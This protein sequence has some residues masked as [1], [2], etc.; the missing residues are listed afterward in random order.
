MTLADLDGDGQAEIL[1]GTSVYNADGS[2]R[3]DRRTLSP[4]YV[5]GSSAGHAAQ[6]AVDFDLDGTLEIIAGPSAYDRDGNRLWFWQRISGTTLRGTLDGGA[7]V[8][9]VPSNSSL[10]DAYT[11]VAN[12]DDDPFPEIIAVSTHPGAVT[13]FAEHSIQVFEH[14]GRLKVDFPLFQNTGPL[15][16]HLGPPTVADVN[17]DGRPDIAVV[18]VKQPSPAPT[19]DLPRPILQV[20]A[21]QADNTLHLQWQ[22]DL[23][24]T[25]NPYP[26]P[27]SAFDFDGDGAAELVVLDNHRL[28]ILYGRDGTTLFEM[29]VD[30]TAG[31][32]FASRYPTIADVDNDGSADIIVPTSFIG[33]AQAGAPPRQGLL[34]LSD[35]Q[36]HWLN[37]RRVWNQHPYHVTNVNED[38]S[39]PRLPRHNW[40]IYNTHRTQSQ[41]E[42]ETAFAAPDLT[43]S[44]VTVQTEHCPAFLGLTARIGNGGSWHAPAGLP[45]DFYNGHPG[46]GGTLLGSRQTTR[47]LDPGAFEDVT[48]EWP[49]LAPAQV[50]VTVNH[51]PQPTAVPSN[52]LVQLAHTWAQGSGFLANSTT[53]FN[54]QAWFGIDGDTN[55]HWRERPVGTNYIPTGEPF[56][57]VRFPFPVNATGVQ[58][59]N[60]LNV[61]LNEAFQGTGTLTFSNGFSAPFTFDANGEGVVAFPEQQ[62]ITWMRVTSTATKANGAALSELS[63][64]GS[65]LEPQFRLNEGTGQLDNNIAASSPGIPACGTQTNQPPLITSAPPIAAKTDTAYLYQVRAFDP[66]NDPLTF[67]LVAAPAG[68]SIDG[69]TGLLQ[70]TPTSRQ[71]GDHAVTVRVQD[72]GGLVATQHFSLAV[73]ASPGPATVPQVVGM[74]QAQAEAFILGAT[75]TVGAIATTSSITVPAGQVLS[76]APPSG[77]LV[78]Q[79]SPVQ[80]VVSLGAAAVAVP[81]VVGMTQPQ[82]EQT[83]ALALLN[84]GRRTTVGSATVPAG[85]VLSQA[86]AAGTLVA[87]GAAVALEV[88]LGALAVPVPHVVGMVRAQAEAT[89]GAIHLVAGPITTAHS[90]TV[91]VGHVLIQAPVAGTTVAQGTTVA[92]QVSL[93][94]VPERDDDGDGFSVSQGDCNDAD[95]TIRP[96]TRDLPGNGVDE[97]C[98]GADAVAGDTTP[99]VASLAVPL[100]DAVVLSPTD[101]IGTVNDANFLRHTLSLARVSDTTFTPVASGTTPVVDGVLGR[102]DP[103]LL[104]NGLYRLR[105]TAE[106]R[107]SQKTSQEIVVQVQG[108]AKVGVVRLSFVDM[109]LPVVGIPI[110]VTRTYDSRVKAL[111][112][113]GVGWSLDLT[114]GSFEHNRK[115]GRG[116]AAHLHLP[117]PRRAMSG[118]YARPCPTSPK[119]V[120]RIA[121]SISSGSPWTTRPSSAG[122][123]WPKPASSLSTASC[124]VPPWRFWAI[125]AWCTRAVPTWCW[126]T[127]PLRCTNR[128]RYV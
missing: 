109:H 56:F 25:S 11:A 110:T 44:R 58:L 100:L 59:E 101:V 90:A 93:G 80:L 1:Y 103:T 50:F 16:F 48:F 99:P 55:T 73:T 40:Q 57:E 114:A 122:A 36:D 68:M 13:Q 70:W 105:L 66:N 8:V 31:P 112:D 60:H 115:P 125:P 51:P 97:D 104:E 15:S 102:L 9:T 82:A 127:P 19:A 121:R 39:I 89:L 126:T 35:T 28:S 128:P 69:S 116:L 107:N 7:T 64:A 124:P 118:D 26:I 14:D 91:P 46:T 5:G 37:A 4:D 17:G 63:V 18:V 43:V 22:R 86:P 106:D 77:M 41:A 20:Y 24:G 29:G 27:V 71:A 87:R 120:F 38:A 23:L 32:A 61:S 34:V 78:A 67:A 6:L 72:T 76:Q 81:D 85:Q 45:V 98:N 65:Y 92:L 2:I 111:R 42:G 123:V 30:S 108:E 33:N 117:T 95:R 94:P 96:G 53:G 12:L 62:G 113:F 84:V 47:A 3:F 52:N 88:S 10:G 21:Y 54:R 74:P 75:L 119:C 83:V 49:G 79:G